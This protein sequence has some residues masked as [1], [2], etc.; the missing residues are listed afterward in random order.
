[1]NRKIKRGIFLKKYQYAFIEGTSGPSS[2]CALIL[3]PT[4]D[5]LKSITSSDYLVKSYRKLLPDDYS[6]YLISY[7]KELTVD[8]TMDILVEDLHD[9]IVSEKIE[10]TVVIGISYGGKIAIQLAGQ[11]PDITEKLLLLTSAHELS[12][13][14]LRFCNECIRKAKTGDRYGMLKLFNTLYQNTLYRIGSDILLFFKYHIINWFSPTDYNSLSTIVY[15]YTYMIEHNADT[16]TYLPL[17]K[18]KTLVLGGDSDPL[19]SEFT[20]IE[21]A[22]EIP[23]RKGQVEIYDN[24]GHMMLV[25]QHANCVKSISIFLK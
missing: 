1:M 3:P 2:K 10:P 17:I 21:T 5:L 25:E 20:Y 15:A 24:S 13:N 6:F 11:F 23:D 22:Q 12:E 19:F 16:Q 7:E 8:H 9:I 4:A 14:G 18:A